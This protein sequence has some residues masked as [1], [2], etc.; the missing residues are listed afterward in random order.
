[1]TTHDFEHPAPDNIS[2]DAIR[3]W[4]ICAGCLLAVLVWAQAAQHAGDGFYCK[5]CGTML[6]ALG[7]FLLSHGAIDTPEGDKRYDI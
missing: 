7:G 3:T 6:P 4:L 1:M 2:P 5:D